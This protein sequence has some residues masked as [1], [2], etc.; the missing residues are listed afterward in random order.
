M[1]LEFACRRHNFHKR[2]YSFQ[3]RDGHIRDTNMPDQPL[4]YECLSL[5]LST[6]KLFH[7]VWFGVRI[8]G[9]YITS[10]C[11]IVRERPVDKEHVDIITLQVCN[12]LSAGFLHSFVHIVPNFCHNIKLFT[13]YHAFVKCSFEDLPDLVFI[14]ISCRTVEH[15]VATSDCACHRV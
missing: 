2:Q 3:F 8:S 13:L 4:F 14:S 12:A 11:M 1:K 6:H 5:P 10:W 9:V 7:S 15:A